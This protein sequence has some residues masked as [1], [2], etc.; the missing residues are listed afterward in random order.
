M[1]GKIHYHRRSDPNRKGG[2]VTA[3]QP[4]HL[5]WLNGPDVARLALTDDEILA[6]VETGL[7]ALGEGRT[8]IEPRVHRRICPRCALGE[9]ARVEG[10]LSAPASAPASDRRPSAPP[11]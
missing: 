8:V 7:K 2:A 4:I 9:P 1:T 5:T 10:N 11:G 6:A 3:T